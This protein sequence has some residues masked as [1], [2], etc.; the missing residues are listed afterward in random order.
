[1][2]AI[3]EDNLGVL[4]HV[5]KRDIKA[6]TKITLTVENLAAVMDATRNDERANLV[7]KQLDAALQTL[8]GIS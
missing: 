3:S 5:F 4:K 6:G 7:E 8:K 2:I 1:M